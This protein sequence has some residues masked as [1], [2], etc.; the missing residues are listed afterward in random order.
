MAD[1]LPARSRGPSRQGAR[2]RRDEPTKEQLYQEA[3]RLGIEGRSK[4]NKRQLA[5][6]VARRRGRT[7]RGSSRVEASPID[8]QRFLE[9]VNYPVRRS[10][11]VDHA[12]RRG[13]NEDVRATLERL[14]D[15]QFESPT[16]VSEAIGRLG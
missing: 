4:M 12:G 7:D 15:E 6:A 2:R 9:D 3:R 13:A 16:E 14:P 1:R 5:D 8:V 10:T 11:L